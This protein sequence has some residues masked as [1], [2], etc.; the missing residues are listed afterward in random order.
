M[1]VENNQE[2]PK[3]ANEKPYDTR[4]ILQ[5]DTQYVQHN[6]NILDTFNG[7]LGKEIKVQ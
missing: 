7:D 5:S 6:I 1:D 3:V 2:D 4:L